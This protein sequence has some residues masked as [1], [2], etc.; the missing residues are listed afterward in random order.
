MAFK[1][2]TIPIW[3]N[4]QVG[5]KGTA[6]TALSDT[7]DLR[8]IAA[9]GSF[10]LTYSIAGTNGG[11]AGSTTF[12]SLGCATA[13]GTFVTLGTF[14]TQGAAA[15]SGVV[16]FTPPVIPFMKIKAVSGTSNP[17]LLTAELNVR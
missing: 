13:S 9:V 5:A 1:I 17:A 4:T 11:T 10:S 15:V 3:K 7:I 16:A 12:E 8:D 2:N 6:G 14:G